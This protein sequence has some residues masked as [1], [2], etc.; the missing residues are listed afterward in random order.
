MQN[1]KKKQK[2]NKNKERLNLIKE[3]FLKIES[4]YKLQ[5]FSEKL[6]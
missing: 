4:K 5:F 3:I 1:K 2:L 6:K